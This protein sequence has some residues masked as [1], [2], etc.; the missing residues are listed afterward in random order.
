[1]LT[2]PKAGVSAPGFVLISNE[3]GTASMETENSA[4]CDA[5][6]APHHTEISYTN[7]PMSHEGLLKHGL[8]Q[9]NAL[10]LALSRVAE[11]DTWRGEPSPDRFSNDLLHNVVT[12]Q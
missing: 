11:N 6:S 12:E 9:R 3:G 4:T 7:L 10:S 2:K 8:T 1:M 5:A